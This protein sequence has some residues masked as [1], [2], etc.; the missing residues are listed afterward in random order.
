MKKLLVIIIISYFSITSANSTKLDG[1][2]NINSLLEQG[3]ELHSTSL[4]KY[5]QYQ[6]HL[7]S[8]G[9]NGKHRLMTCVY[10]IEQ[11]VALCW[12]P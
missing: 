1:S 5:G 11:E 2:Q 8:D 10:F 7:I 4:I 6:Y 9:S 12:V 3:Y